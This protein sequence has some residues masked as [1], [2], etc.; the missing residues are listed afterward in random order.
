MEESYTREY[1]A[2][3]HTHTDSSS[4]SS[5]ANKTTPPAYYNT[6][7]HT[8]SGIT[9]S[10]EPT[11]FSLHNHA[12]NVPDLA[13]VAVCRFVIAFVGC[14]LL[15]AGCLLPAVRNGTAADAATAAQLH[16]QNSATTS[17][18]VYECS[19]Y[20]MPHTNSWCRPWKIYILWMEMYIIYVYACTKWTV[21][22]CL[23][24]LLWLITVVVRRRCLLPLLSLLLASF[25]FLS[26]VFFSFERGFCASFEHN[27]MLIP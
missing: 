13:S 1:W 20:A 3:W 6:H 17:I 26:C 7:I 23:L 21:L 12:L 5:S 2:K 8:V 18:S 15:D 25:P 27:V 19:V 11:I 24:V 22:L 10:P 4:G 16:Q 14:W 9:A